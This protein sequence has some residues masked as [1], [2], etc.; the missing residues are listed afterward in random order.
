MLSKAL[1]LVCAA[2]LCL[3]AKS[4]YVR[5][6]VLS[7]LHCIRD[8]FKANSKCNPKVLG[9]IQSEYNIPSLPFDTPYFNASYVDQNLF[10]RN[11]DKCVVSEFFFNTESDTAVFAIDC[12]GIEFESDRLMLQHYSLKEDTKYNYHVRATY[13]LVRLTMNVQRAN[14]LNICNAFTF[15]DVTALPIFYIDP[16]DRS[17]ANFLSTD[18]TFIN[19]YE[20]ELFASRANFVIRYFINSYICDFGCN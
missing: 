7:D 11:H 3:A 5:P 15:A 16:K 8:N 17:T 20:R 1:I 6:C 4:K 12:P 19:I 10:V 9:S 18:L 13:P 14:K 2:T